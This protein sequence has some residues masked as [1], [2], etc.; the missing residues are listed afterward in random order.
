MIGNLTIDKS[1]MNLSYFLYSVKI[2]ADSAGDITRASFVKE[3]ATFASL[4]EIT[5]DGKENR[6]AYNKSKLPR[7]FGFIDTYVDGSNVQHLVL[8]RRGAALLEMIEANYGNEADHFY[9][10]KT[11]MKIEFT[12]L[13][14]ES[15]LYGRFGRN[16]PGA[17]KS[18]TDLEPP[19]V[20]FR[21][22]T[23]L[24]YIT[25]Q[26]YCFLLFSL[27]SHKFPNYEAAL[28]E[29]KKRRINK[30]DFY[31]AEL[32]Q[33]G[34]YNLAN[35][36]K[37]IT[38]FTDESIGLIRKVDNGSEKRLYLSNWAKE[39]YSN[40]L[41]IISPVYKPI[42]LFVGTSPCIE[43]QRQVL[44]DTVLGGVTD[45]NMTIWCGHDQNLFG[46]IKNGV[47]MPS[48][49]EKTLRKAFMSPDKAVYLILEGC[50]VADIIKCFGDFAPLLNYETDV[51]AE[52]C[53]WS[54]ESIRAPEFEKWLYQ[55]TNGQVDLRGKGITIP[56]NLNIIGVKTMDTNNGTYDYG[57]SKCFI[58]GEDSP[59]NGESAPQ[60]LPGLN[61]IVYGT[62]GCGKSYFVENKLLAS[63]QY[64]LAGITKNGLG[65]P[66]SSR[67]RTTFY[68]DYTN[69]DFVGQILP[70]V[71]GGVVT[72]SFRPG[73]FTLALR[74]ALDP[75]NE[76]K[77]VALIIE[78]LNRGS[79]ASIFG[80]IFQ[81]LDRDSSGKSV[82]SIS[83]INISR[84]LN[85]SFKDD[86]KWRQLSEIYIPSN[87]FIIA[88]MN[89]SDQ[90]VFTLDAAFKRRW[91]FEKLANEFTSEHDY[92][93]YS[94]PGFN[95]DY[96]YES[97]I[98][99]IN[100]YMVANSDQFMNEDKQI[101]IYFL[102][103]GQLIK[104]KVTA[105]TTE[106]KREVAFK[107][108]E[109]LWDDVSRMQHDFMFQGTIK[110]L[111]DLLAAF[112]KD[113]EKVFTQDLQDL[114]EKNK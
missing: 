61:L 71:D 88:T 65:I 83:N 3:M 73:P 59:L 111:D 8:T 63:G 40:H 97:I 99:S 24:N 81:L 91:K 31:D 55:T 79:A 109:Y 22:L 35:D 85:E 29:V 112:E 75:K 41:K 107:L 89:T 1:S 54:T 72:Y 113:G 77:P 47:Y 87:L 37:L 2:V 110:T 16:N 6:T 66:S 96:T 13:I 103:K 95:P 52:K 4:P 57:F 15:V 45:D 86:P 7:Y 114:F 12:D 49:F 101:G 30:T 43:N 56:A 5:E 33:L 32:T 92:K 36:C 26:E 102:E 90:N 44:F 69:T 19:K 104:D 25:S 108:L 80:D 98:K 38:I 78:E 70:N 51:F 17:E 21:M 14:F 82:Y 100:E 67:I 94:V 11:E 64:E 18:C 105:P 20:L 93:G 50:E 42:R 10:I 74:K 62:P 58:E 106:Q 48:A 68:Q 27:N 53:G 60:T 84:F 39:K 9:S 28:S 46:S 34:V 23:D 76:G